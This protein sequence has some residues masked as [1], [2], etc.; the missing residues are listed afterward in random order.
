MLSDKAVCRTAP[1]TLGL[2]KT[3]KRSSHLFHSSKTVLL[4]VGLCLV[5]LGCLGECLEA[6][7]SEDFLFGVLWGLGCLE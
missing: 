7:V 2:F 5:E 1:A 6:L 3:C 4:S